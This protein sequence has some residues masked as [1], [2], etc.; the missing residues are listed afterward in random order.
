MNKSKKYILVTGCIGLLSVIIGGREYEI[1]S[2][3][4]MTVAQQVRVA[5]DE[6]TLTSASHEQEAA[7]LHTVGPSGS[8][9]LAVP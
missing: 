6:T 1:T 5:S 2:P 3:G 9:V 7:V 8:G 4:A